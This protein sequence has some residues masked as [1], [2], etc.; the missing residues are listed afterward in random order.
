[1]VS[2]V[3]ERESGSGGVPARRG[4]KYQDHVAAQLVLKMLE[5]PRIVQIE[6]ETSDDITIVWST[7]TG[8]HSEYVQVKTTDADRKWS[9]AE[10]KQ[11]EIRNR[12][13]SLIEKSLL[14]D[15]LG[16]NARFRIVTSRDVRKELACLTIPFAKRTADSSLEELAVYMAGVY[17]TT[18]GNGNGL[19][20]WA[21]NTYWQITGDMEALESANAWEIARIA[22]QEGTNPSHS[23]TLEIYRDLMSKVD[24]AALAPKETSASE[25]VITREQALDWWRTHL[26]QTDAA[27]KATSKPYRIRTE[28]FFAQVHHFTEAEFRRLV[29]GYDAQFELGTWRAEP[30]ATY[31]A[32]WLPELA[33]KASELVQV[34]HLNLRQKLATAVKKIEAERSIEPERVLAE[35][36]LHVILRHHF[37]SE[38]TACKLFYK[39]IYG[40]LASGSAHIVRVDGREELWLG[41]AKIATIEARSAEI[42]AIRAELEACLD[43]ALL[44]DE[45]EVILSLREPKHL[46]SFDIERCLRKHA[47]LDQL[48]EV[49]C[50]PILLGYD[51]GV[52]ARGYSSDYERELIAEI[53]QV[54]QDIVSVLPSTGIKAKIHVFL[55]PVECVR[56]LVELFQKKIRG[57]I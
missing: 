48:L 31:L 43:P 50:L 16:A 1:V 57:E 23:H 25:K 8:I 38:P 17:T 24:K 2:T 15:R 27:L 56:T 46:Q 4:F 12:P 35:M 28:A 10:L 53:E 42:S 40:T 32:E 33:L 9:R 26:D 45:R 20:Y 13:T 39:T 34:N 14:C 30:L 44:K 55:I 22:E 41:R 54:Y 36:L 21:R 29:T 11:R 7:E 3:S 49:L 52:L 47:P 37:G 19:G 6:C 51:S 18:S 5:D